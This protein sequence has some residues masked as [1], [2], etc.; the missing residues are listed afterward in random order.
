MNAIHRHQ[1]AVAERR[2]RSQLTTLAREKLPD[3]PGKILI[4]ALVTFP[5]RAYS[6]AHRHPGSVMT[7]VL[8]GTL[9]SQLSGGPPRDYS[10]GATMFEPAGALHIFAENPSETHAAQLLAVFIADDDDAPLVVRARNE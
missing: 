2:P 5:P 6:A 3:V 9:R 10:A 4:T 1:P 8:T 7:L